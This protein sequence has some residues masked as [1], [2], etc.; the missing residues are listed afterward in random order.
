ALIDVA[1]PVEDVDVDALSTSLLDTLDPYYGVSLKPINPGG[2][3]RSCS[4][5]LVRFRLKL[6]SSYTLML[7]S[8]VTIEGMGKKLDPDFDITALAR[9]FVEQLIVERWKPKRLAHDFEL[10][11]LDVSSLVRRVPQQIV[12]ILH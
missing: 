2:L 10:A 1:E 5:L 9:P 11:A 8:L 3:I 4:R 12:G 7:K 6:P